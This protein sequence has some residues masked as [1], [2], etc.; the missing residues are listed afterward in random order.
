[1]VLRPVLLAAGLLVPA[2]LLLAGCGADFVYFESNQI[3]GAGTTTLIVAWRDAPADGAE[4]VR[5]TLDRVEVYGPEGTEVLAE[6]RQVHDL[7]TLVNGV[8]A[9]V[10]SAEIPAGRW[11]GLRF[12]LADEAGAHTVRVD[13]AV[14]VLVFAR[15]GGWIVEVPRV[16]ELEEDATTEVVVDFDVRLSVYAAGDTWFLD[17]RLAPVDPAGGGGVEGTVLSLIHI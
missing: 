11:D 15:P 9:R 4:S 1:M 12:V 17:P 10:A 3:S 7:L 16:L 14:H 6:G 13:G 5:V 2:L 8:T